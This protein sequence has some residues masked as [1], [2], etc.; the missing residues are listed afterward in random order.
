MRGSAGMVSAPLCAQR[1]P[2][3]VHL[4][5]ASGLRGRRRGAGANVRPGRAV[6]GWL[7]LEART[8]VLARLVYVDHV[9]GVV[10][11]VLRRRVL[12]NLIAAGIGDVQRAVVVLAELA[13]GRVTAKPMAF[14]IARAAARE[15]I[16]AERQAGV[17]EAHSRGHSIP[18][19]ADNNS[20]KGHGR[21]AGRGGGQALLRRLHWRG[22]GHSDSAVR[23]EPPVTREAY[24]HRPCAVCGEIDGEISG[25]EAAHLG[26]LHHDHGLVADAEAVGPRVSTG[27]PRPF[28]RKHRLPAGKRIAVRGA[29]RYLFRRRRLWL[30]VTA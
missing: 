20:K 8:V 5:K 16:A 19:L 17:D 29:R 12:A 3:L 6:A 14:S 30:I 28:R 1:V 11:L 7:T 13:A 4:A 10:H 23:N 27:R 22:V 9:A 26:E 21:R 25:V 24:R 18:P 15:L 2:D